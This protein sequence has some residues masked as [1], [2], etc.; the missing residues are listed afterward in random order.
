[1]KWVGYDDPTWEP[2]SRLNGCIKLID[3]YRSKTTPLRRSTR[4]RAR[5]SKSDKMAAFTADAIAINPLNKITTGQHAGRVVY[6]I[7]D[8]H[9]HSTDLNDGSDGTDTILG[10]T[11]Y[12]VQF[13]EPWNH[14]SLAVWLS[15]AVLNRDVPGILW[16]YEDRRY[17]INRAHAFSLR[18]LDG[19]DGSDTQDTDT[20]LTSQT[21]S[22]FL[23][24]RYAKEIS[25]KI[26]E[27]QLRHQLSSYVLYHLRPKRYLMHLS[28]RYDTLRCDRQTAI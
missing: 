4:L 12:L 11:S 20:N 5:T 9:V 2:R 3:E 21:D 14:D 16:A 6:K 1:M 15:K 17:A 13:D 23:T 26:N 8:K 18:T 22:E 28:Q 10:D 24:T 27:L 7:L 25:D 19:G